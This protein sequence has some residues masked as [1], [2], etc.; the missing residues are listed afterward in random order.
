MKFGVVGDPVSHSRSPAIHRAGFAA[1]GVDATYDFL[2]TPPD[3]FATIVERLRTGELTG[4]N[5]TMPHKDHAF[6]A[7]DTVSASAARTRSVNT[8]VRE[9]GVLAGYNTDVDGVR[10]ALRIVGE[11]ES[12]VL[13][14]GSGGAARAAIVALEHLD[15]TVATRRR[16]S[17]EEASSATGV[18]VAVVP[19]GS[20][21]PGAV[22]VNATPVGM[23]G[24]GL[25]AE[26][27]TQASAVIDMAYGD[28]VTPAVAWARDHG[29]PVADG[30]DMLVGQAATA[31]A[32]F[33]GHEPPLEA[34]ASAARG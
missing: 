8:I 30:I 1:V 12:R 23:H 4:V 32:H 11:P 6:D 2:P 10:Y 22:I 13:I 33:T 31:F 15:I 19:W 21:V 26:V 5:V 34:M 7:A 16:V 27:V 29:V 28:D 9:H 24:E 17:A 18:D 25:P 3:G 20:G 14:L